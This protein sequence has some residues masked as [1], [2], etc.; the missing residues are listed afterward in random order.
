MKCNVTNFTKVERIKNLI[1][2]ANISD[3]TINYTTSPESSTI[4]SETSTNATPEINKINK[5]Q[6]FQFHNVIFFLREIHVFHTIK[7]LRKK[8]FP[9]TIYRCF[10]EI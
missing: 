7:T 5:N 1:I 3:S 4:L 8:K 9:F 2:A 6:K 10:W